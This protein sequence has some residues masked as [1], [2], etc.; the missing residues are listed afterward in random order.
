[1]ALINCP[2][3]GAQVSDQAVSCPNCGH[4]IKPAGKPHPWQPMGIGWMAIAV[5]TLVA[6]LFILINTCNWKPVV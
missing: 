1:M 6:A 2:E 3:C 4:P 5:I